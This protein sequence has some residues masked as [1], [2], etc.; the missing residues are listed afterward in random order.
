MRIFFYF[1]FAC[2][3]YLYRMLPVRANLVVMIKTHDRGLEGNIGEVYRELTRHHPEFRYYWID[4]KYE[5]MVGLRKVLHVISFFFL[6]SYHLARAKYVFLD[7][8]FL[9]MA[10]MKFP[11]DTRIIQLWHGCGAIKKFGQD[12]NR[13]II[14]WLERK[15]NL[16]YT[17]LVVNSKA[18]IPQTLNA[19][20][21]SKDKIR[22]LGCPRTDYFFNQD[23]IIVGIKRFYSKYPHLKGKKLLLYCPT[24]RDHEIKNPKWNLNFIDLL[25]KLGQQYVLLLRAHPFVAK[26][27]KIKEHS[28]VVDVSD[29]EDL[30]G[31]LSV[32]DILITD[33]SSIIFEYSLLN[34]PM[35][36]YAYDLE[37]F[38]TNG[39]GFYESYEDLV[40]GD[41]P[42]LTVSP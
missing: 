12:V 18:V 41:I 36:F 29:Y 35:I 22:V 21:I 25:E 14:A 15:A 42:S 6:G 11:K 19:F 10:F 38:K 33:Y 34:R 37:Q 1:L 26:Y 31:L 23:R 17:D 2:L 16:T 32:S 30:N 5:E 4:K 39:R 13:G 20:G 27:C 9:P 40:P 3:F 7:N 24:F 8:V 28:S